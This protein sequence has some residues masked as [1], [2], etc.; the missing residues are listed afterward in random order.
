MLV[1]I[2]DILKVSA[3][4]GYSEHHSGRALDITTPGYDVLEE[5]FEASPAFR[6]LE[7]NA[8]HYRFRL[9]Y[10]RDN[11]HGVVYE[12]WHWYWHGQNQAQAI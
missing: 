11:P 1:C 5:V 8:S 3:A 10:P 4:P 12:P 2:E 7:K 6:W 9:S